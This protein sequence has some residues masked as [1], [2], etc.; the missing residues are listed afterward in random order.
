[1]ARSLM[2]SGEGVN[3]KTG[4]HITFQIP[5]PFPEKA[6]EA[7]FRNVIVEKCEHRSADCDP[8]FVQRLVCGR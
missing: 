6:Q 3:Q 5:A 4:K 7:F 1:M 8:K 2:F